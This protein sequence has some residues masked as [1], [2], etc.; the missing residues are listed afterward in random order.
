MP[1]IVDPNT[2]TLLWESGAINTYLV[3]TYDKDHK[4]SYESSRERHLC[5]Q[6]LHF[7]MSGQGPYFGQAAWFS[8]FHAE[9]LPSAI[10]RYR[11]EIER[12]IGVLNTH[13]EKQGTGYLVGDKCT[14]ADLAFVT[15]SNIVPGLMGEERKID[16]EG[17]FP[18]YDKWLKGLNERASV[19][20]VN[21]IK[22]KAKAEKEAK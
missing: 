2:D 3:E 6:W 10:E 18:A 4:I 9:K 16:F 1:A 7:Q 21:E 13:L 19:K 22:E 14:Y 11:N 20:K 15:W 17:K 8:F 12:V 5:N